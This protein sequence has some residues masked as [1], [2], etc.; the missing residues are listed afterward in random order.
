V[1][2]QRRDQPAEDAGLV[3]AAR[4]PS[5]QDETDGFTLYRND[6]ATLADLAWIRLASATIEA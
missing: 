1:L 4:A 2:G 6:G 5:G 3:R